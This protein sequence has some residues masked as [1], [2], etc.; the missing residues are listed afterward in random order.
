MRVEFL[1][2]QDE[3][4]IAKRIEHRR[5]SILGSETQ[6]ASRASGLQITHSARSE[7][8]RVPRDFI[9]SGAVSVVSPTELTDI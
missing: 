8:R 2:D 3:R 1:A 6:C 7:S 5:L 9:A 4:L